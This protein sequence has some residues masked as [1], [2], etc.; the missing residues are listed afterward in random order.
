MSRIRSDKIKK[1]PNKNNIIDLD[2]SKL[3][4]KKDNNHYPYNSEEWRFKINE[5]QYLYLNK[6][7]DEE[8]FNS[9]ISIIIDF[10]YFLKNN[11]NILSD[12]T[13]ESY[14]SN[15][16]LLLKYEKE[17][18]LKI[19]K[20]SDINHYFLLNYCNYLKQKNFTL[21]VYD[22]IRALLKRLSKTENII[23]HNDIINNIFPSIDLSVDKN[24][25]EH[26]TEEE[27]QYLAKFITSSLKSYFEKKSGFTYKN[28]TKCAYWYISM[29][30]GLN[31]TALNSL[32]PESIEKIKENDEVDIYWIVGEKNRNNKKYQ[33]T[34]FAIKK[35]NNLFRQVLDELIINYNN[36]SK[37]Y[38]NITLFSYIGLTGLNRYQGRGEEINILN[39]FKSYLIE[40]PT[41]FKV[42][43]LNSSTIRNFLSASVY[44]KTKDEKVVSVML[45]HENISMTNT[46]YM[47]HKI[48]HKI[49]LKFNTIQELIYSFSKNKNFD[50]WINFQNSLNLKDTELDVI[51][52]R[53][54]DGFYSSQLGQCI[55]H[56]NKNENICTSYINCFECKHFSIIGERDAWKLISFKES[57]IELKGKS[58]LYNWLYSLID[59]I[60]ISFEKE[61]LIES[62]KLLKE[63]GRHPFWKNQIMIK[64]ITE[65]YEKNL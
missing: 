60:L 65:Q 13:L 7:V 33:N 10:K 61:I 20:F 15:L 2:I 24:L 47:K 45:D 42:P 49:L 28:F 25:K 4:V 51:I 38:K 8:D 58:D 48:D 43:N 31:K 52:N 21:S 19:H 59:N 40:N 22:T 63:K 53:L 17:S 46:H 9:K 3:I 64:N 37:D 6:L 56:V 41:T 57:L 1:K 35:D 26:Y 55:R 14:C 27:F 29:L 18:N 16:K 5:K 62:R 30:S 54:K 44:H 32:I 11:K 23:M 36:L 50:D 34:I 39:I 12:K